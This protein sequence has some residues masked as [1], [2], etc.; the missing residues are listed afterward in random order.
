MSTWC[1]AGGPSTQ[2][3]T[4]AAPTTAAPTT[5]APTAA[6]TTAA[7][8]TQA[9]TTEAPRGWVTGTWTTG[10]WD[11]CKPSCS[12]PGKG[13]VDQPT[14]SCD[15]AT[16]EKL[17]DP[18]VQSVCTGG[19]AAS[20]TSN[21]PF[22]VNRGLSMGFAAA[23]VS[24]EHGLTGDTNCG[25]CFELRFVDQK[26]DPSG[27]NWGGAHP[28]LVGK[29]M[30]VQVTNIG[31]DVLGD[32]SFDLQ[33]P[34]AGQG[35]FDGGCAAQFPEKQVDDFDCGQRY[36]GC[37]AKSGCSRL[38][39]ELQA[40]CEWRY[41]WYRWLV[42]GGQTNN[43]YAHFRRVACPAQLTVISGSVATDDDEFP[44]INPDDYA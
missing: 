38:P 17:F 4:T 37:S 12:W 19:T 26:H 32:H 44:T 42:N 29:T 18:N 8:T 43:P 10:Y 22:I 9:P 24:G 23:A 31:Y 27:D 35:A 28:D 3:P 34:G 16:G 41:D 20:C 33:I 39:P 5:V 11:C 36:G 6:P 30:V 14:L 15:A 13:N 25:Q 1:E 21:R 2:A 40:G 7:P